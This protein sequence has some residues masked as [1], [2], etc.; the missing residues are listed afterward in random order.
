MQRIIELVTPSIFQTLNM[1]VITTFFTVLIGLPLGLLLV[2]ISKDHILENRKLYAVLSYIVNMLRSIPF[3]ILL[4]YLLGF[5]R[6]IVGSGIGTQAAI[7][8]LVIAS[9][10]FF[11]RIVE[12]A[13]LEVDK[14]V[15]EAARA[16]GASPLQI[17]TRV[18]IPESMRSLTL[19]ITIAMINIM[20]YT[21]IAGIIGAGGLGDLAIR[22]GFHRKQTD[23]MNIT[24]IILI[25]LVQVIQ[26]LGY[27]VA[28]RF[29]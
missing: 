10:P 4:V 7:P 11:A 20:G 8:P 14:G 16:M 19:N 13:V 2:V 28:K 24:I 1:V 5:T 27:A 23:V 9:I 17:I 6:M 12:T 3:L 18:L 25:V 26:S 29:K 22:Y 15:I 21:A